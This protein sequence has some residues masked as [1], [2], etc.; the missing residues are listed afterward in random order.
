[1]PDFTIPA[2]EE[3]ALRAWADANDCPPWA[4][5]ES[6]ARI[7]HTIESA[8]GFLLFLMGSEMKLSLY[9]ST[10]WS[11]CGARMALALGAPPESLR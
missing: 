5:A 8:T 2:R 3:G 6:R 7:A 4:V 1:M 9:Q 10:G 11:P